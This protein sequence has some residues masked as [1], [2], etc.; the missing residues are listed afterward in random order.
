MCQVSDQFDYYSCPYD[1]DT[2]P[3][4]CGEKPECSHCT[5]CAFATGKK[6][7]KERRERCAA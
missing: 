5:W 2:G 4:P 7:T 3:V 6:P 1:P